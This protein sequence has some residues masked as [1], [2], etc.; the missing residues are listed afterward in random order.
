VKEKHNRNRKHIC[1]KWKIYIE[2]VPHTHTKCA[3]KKTKY[4]GWND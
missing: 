4:W 1:A 2:N 3:L